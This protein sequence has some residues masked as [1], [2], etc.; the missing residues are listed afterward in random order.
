MGNWPSSLLKRPICMPFQELVILLNTTVARIGHIKQGILGV[1]FLPLNIIKLLLIPY[2]GW[3]TIMSSN[4]VNSSLFQFDRM[5]VHFYSQLVPIFTNIRSIS[6]YYFLDNY[7]HFFG[8][9]KAKSH[10][11]QLFSRRHIGTLGCWNGNSCDTSVQL[12]STISHFSFT[13]PVTR[14]TRVA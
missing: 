6:L 14:V 3:I 13:T 1:F 5:L 7:N 9:K 12:V 11:H 4:R 2:K 10:L 8:D